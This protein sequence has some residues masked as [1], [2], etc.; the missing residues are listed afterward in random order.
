MATA[1]QSRVAAPH[2][3]VLLARA[4]HSSLRSLSSLLSVSVTCLLSALRLQPQ[5]IS[6]DRHRMSENG[7]G[8]MSALDLLGL[9]NLA[10]VLLKL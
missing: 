8:A 4:P 3:T 5:G 7:G 6:R 9:N 10:L 1:G 2:W